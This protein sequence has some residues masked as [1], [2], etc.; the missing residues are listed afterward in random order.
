MATMSSAAFW[1]RVKHPR[2]FSVF[3]EELWAGPR[4]EPRLGPP[5]PN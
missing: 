1:L 4:D 2:V 3:E 5:G